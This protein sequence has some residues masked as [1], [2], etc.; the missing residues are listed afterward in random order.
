[1][2]KPKSKAKC[3]RVSTADKDCMVKHLNYPNHKLKTV[4]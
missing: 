3:Q 1:M 2:P 4:K